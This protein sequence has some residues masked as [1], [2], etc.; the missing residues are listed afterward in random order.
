MD[1]VQQAAGSQTAGGNTPVTTPSTPG[2]LV[3]LNALL[4]ERDQWKQ[5]AEQLES[6]YNGQQSALTTATN[7]K[8]AAQLKAAELQSQYELFQAEATNNKTSWEQER[9]TL[10]Q[11][12]QQLTGQVEKFQ[13]QTAVRTAIGQTSPE[14]VKLYDDGL[15]PGVETLEGDALTGYLTKFK[16]TLDAMRGNA[17][18]QQV[19]GT[20]PT[21]PPAQQGAAMTVEE[22]AKKLL[23]MDPYSKEYANLQAAMFEAAAKK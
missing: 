14:L 1:P 2:Q 18:V 15:M 21:Q 17:V 3:D 5:K 12:V 4:A 10:T 13:K 7:E 22:M 6:R 11:Q 20:T 8:K 23:T 9:A 16:S 19:Q